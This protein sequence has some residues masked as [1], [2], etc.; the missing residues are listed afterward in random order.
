LYEPTTIL[1]PKKNNNNK[2]FEFTS[3]IISFR[4]LLDAVKQN[5]RLED[6]PVGPYKLLEI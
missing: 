2:K 3:H 1:D 5:S 6:V 4:W